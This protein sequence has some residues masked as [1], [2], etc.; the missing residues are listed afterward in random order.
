[1]K[2]APLAPQDAVTQYETLMN[3][4]HTRKVEIYPTF[5]KCWDGARAGVIDVVWATDMVWA[6]SKGEQ[7]GLHAVTCTC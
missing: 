3:G 6:I 5:G 1:M 4:D 7:L 2:L